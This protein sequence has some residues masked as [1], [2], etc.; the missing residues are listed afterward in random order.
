MPSSITTLKHLL[1]LHREAQL[2]I[3]QK[4]R[5]YWEPSRK[6]T[7]RGEKIG[8]SRDKYRAVLLTVRNNILGHS[9]DL[10]ELAKELGVPYGTLRNWQSEGE[11]KALVRQ[12][13]EEFM[14]FALRTRDHSVKATKAR[15]SD[16]FPDTY[17][18]LLRAMEIMKDSKEA[19]RRRMEV[20]ELLSA[21]TEALEKETK[22]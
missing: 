4:L 21:A 17:R 5:E 15:R 10:K 11:F 19:A 1:P 8:F 13:Q 2:F 16:T 22:R 20:I 9:Q 7:T 6:G 18:L 12:H 14:G 3:N